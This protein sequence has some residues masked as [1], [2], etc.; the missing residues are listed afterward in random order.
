MS[1]ASNHLLCRLGLH[2]WEFHPYQPQRDCRLC[3]DRQDLGMKSVSYFFYETFGDWITSLYLGVAYLG[4]IV[5][6]SAILILIHSMRAL[7]N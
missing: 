5:G 3:G 7:F 1:S 2:Y 6:G 4:L